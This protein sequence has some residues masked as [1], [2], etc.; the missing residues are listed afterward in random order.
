MLPTSLCPHCAVKEHLDLLR[1]FNRAAPDAPFFPTQSGQPASKGGGAYD[2]ISHASAHCPVTAPPGRLAGE[3]I[4]CESV[5]CN[6]YLGKSGVEVARFQALARHSS[7]ANLGYLQGAHAQAMTNV[8]TEAASPARSLAS[9]Q[10][11]L[12]AL[13][14]QVNANKPLPPASLSPESTRSVWNPGVHSELHYLRPTD[15]SC[16]RCRWK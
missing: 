4:L 1:G 13:Q 9:L 8:T 3:A 10:K 11:E 2:C 14:T 5:A 7:N 15:L 6:T 12:Q 16:S